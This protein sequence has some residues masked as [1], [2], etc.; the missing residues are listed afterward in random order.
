M[1]RLAVAAL[2][3][4]LVAPACGGG[5]DDGD[6]DRSAR[7]APPPAGTLAY[8]PPDTIGVALVPTDLDGD[9]LHRLAT[10]VNPSLSLRQALTESARDEGL[11][12]ERDVEPLL[13]G[14][15]VV[16]GVDD[17]LFALETPD[18]AAL[19]R[20]VERIVGLA[21]R[22]SRDH[23]R[24][25]VY[26][27][28]VAIDGATI[29]IAG[30]DEALVAAI[31]RRRD[32][33]GLDAAAFE[34]EL[35]EDAS[36]DALVR[37]I[38]TPAAW[39]DDEELRRAA[40]EPWVGAV[41]GFGGVLTLERDAITA[42]LRVRTEPEGL[43]EED[44]PLEA[45]EHAPEVPRVEG[46]FNAA[47]R[48]QSRTTTFLAR[49]ARRLYPDSEFVREV[50]AAERELAIRFEEEVLAQFNGP[51]ASLATPQG[52]FGAVSELG[53][54][55]RMRELLPRLAPHLPGILRGLWGLGNTGLIALLLVA[56]DAPLVPG[57]L[58]ALSAAIKVVPLGGGD[59]EQL[60]FRIDGLDEPGPDGR[61]FGGTGQV[62]FGM[63][64]ERFVVGS[65]ERRAREAGELDVS[66]VDGAQGA[67]VAWADL[68]TIEPETLSR[69]IL[70]QGKPLGE[71]VG[72]LE[73]STDG[74][75]GRLR[76][77]VPGGLE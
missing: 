1:R 39:A 3:L 10:L 24:A 42:R 55:D 73:A 77:E 9:Q 53:D 28:G 45:G 36:A 41:R 2:V 4:A 37:L 43:R 38:G 67:G 35:G 60:L 13:G 44:L 8:F 34:R 58:D 17:I 27:E 47:N 32:G 57:A 20:T 7:G 56:P 74:L 5:D 61:S 76:V 16:G 65:G 70:F 22:G 48:N 75:E 54:P 31:D 52:E 59:D 63:I 21:R 50:E 71:L 68:S 40:A 66:D 15:G 14:T 64:G 33:G 69:L 11:D 51:S 18:E 30:T 6:G 46:A 26:R 62:V 19:R 23:R 12:F 72:E 49:V 29:L 25:T